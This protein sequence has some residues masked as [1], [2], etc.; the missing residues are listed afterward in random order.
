MNRSQ[1]RTGLLLSVGLFCVACDSS[2]D[3]SALSGPYL[4]QEPP[5]FTPVVF[6]PGVVS[7][8]ENE[9][10]ATFTPD[11]DELY[12]SVRQGGQYTLMTLRLENGLWSERSAVSFSGDYGD[13]DPFV[14]S[15]GARIYFSSK[16][17]LDSAGEAKDSD[18][19]FADRTASG[20]W[21]EP[22]HL[23][24]LSSDGADDYYTS[25]SSDGTLYFSRFGAGGE[26]G[27]LYRSAPLDGVFGEPA[28][29]GPPL[30]TGSNE[31]DPFIAP[32]GS[33]LIF[34][35]NRPGGFGNGD[36]YVSSRKAD[37][38][39]SEPINLGEEINSLGNDYCAMLSPDGRYL[40]FTRSFN[41]DGDIYWVDAAIIGRVL[42]SVGNAGAPVHPTR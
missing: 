14:T 12:F 4:G 38:T 24:E 17:P 32:D 18:L 6:A 41:N 2:D 29:L 9:L 26:G 39:W 42:E 28:L 40:F 34:T 27:D 23:A 19:W 36:L 25:V 5:G 13:V 15:D 11:G 1:K 21:N 8:L 3:S 37:S 22:T 20:D 30:S 35:S 7:T 31:H 10:N 16:R 33:F